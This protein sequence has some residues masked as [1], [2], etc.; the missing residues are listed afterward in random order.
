M[1]VSLYR[2]INAQGGYLVYRHCFDVT[3]CTIQEGAAEHKE[4]VFVEEAAAK[5]YCDYRNKLTEQRGD[6]GL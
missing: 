2:Y 5:D 1:S 3:R 6:D 4:A